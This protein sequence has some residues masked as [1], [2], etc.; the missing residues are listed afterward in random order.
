MS[1]FQ[2]TEKA[3]FIFDG[4]E[5]VRQLLWLEF[6][7]V[8]DGFVPLVEQA[9]ESVT[10]VYLT[11]A[12]GLLVDSAVFF[13]IDFDAEGYAD[14]SWNLPL[15][16]L[17]QN[18]AS[19]PDLGGGPI[20]LACRSQCSISWHQNQLWEPELSTDGTHFS[21]I[22]EAVSLNRLLLTGS[23]EHL[24]GSFEQRK[25]GRNN[26]NLRRDNFDDATLVAIR[27]ERDKAIQ[28]LKEQ[29]ASA[30]ALEQRNREELAEVKKNYQSQFQEY[31]LLLQQKEESILQH[32]ENI[33]RLEEQVAGF[34]QKIDGLKE[35]YG[36][37]L[38]SLKSGDK[39]TIDALNKH[40][41][42]ELEE[43][44]ESA[45][46]ELNERLQM[47][48]IEVIYRDTQLS[49][50]QDEVVRLKQ[51]KKSLLESS[52]N[53]LLHQLSKHGVSF[54]AFQPGAGQITL[55]VSS[56]TE[57]MEDRDQ[58]V[59]SKCGVSK[60]VYLAWLA[61]FKR[62]QCIATSADGQLCQ[63]SLERVSEPGDFT[64]GYSD[65][66]SKHRNTS[67]LKNEVSSF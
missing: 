67:P 10:A 24:T 54:V 26:E 60:E 51:D 44:V 59:A 65:R 40:H 57:F 38:E 27:Q 4:P 1:N 31:Q 12:P 42:I 50:L 47:R 34:Q 39:A 58:F 61:H 11:I 35:Y 6:E 56:L 3:V 23:E 52:G 41:Q 16:Q 7:A 18:S 20:K 43:R 29:G 37:K 28:E 9:S 46:R 2:E 5:L 48:D 55:P 53:Q 66:C 8:L 49:A 15:E 21:T 64:P 13:L 63:C 32:K 62:P 33:A 19:G 25:G 45:C 30:K 17:A 14:K 36:H 22:K